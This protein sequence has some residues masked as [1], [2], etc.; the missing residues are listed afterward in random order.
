MKLPLNILFAAILLG[1]SGAAFAH[2]EET[3]RLVSVSGEAEVTAIPD[4][5]IVNMSV[6]S[7]NRELPAARDQVA[8]VAARFIQLA[9]QLG[10][11]KSQIQTSQ[12]TVRPEYEWIKSSRERRLTGYYVS[13]Q[14]TVDLRDLDKLGALME[15]ATAAGVNNVSPPQLD[16]SRRKEL[17][18][19]A[20][21]RAATD[22]R[23]NAQVLATAMGATLGNIHRID[24]GG[25]HHPQPVMMRERVMAMDSAGAK[26]EQ[27]YETGSIRFR[28]S[29]SA[30]FLLQ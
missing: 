30:S 2:S 23:Q 14:L 24:A 25:G 13:R 17:H 11:P 12:Q 15:R 21:K 7:R 6:E 3:S 28:A 8:S 29:V 20:L 16:S 22:A 5:A 26:A 10:V 9:E 1:L 4:R 27:T 18:R 19:E